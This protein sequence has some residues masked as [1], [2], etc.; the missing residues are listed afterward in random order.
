MTYREERAPKPLAAAVAEYLQSKDKESERHLLSHRQLRSIRNEMES[1][2]RHF[3]SGPIDRL[4]RDNLLAYLERGNPELKTYNNRRGLLSTFLKFAFRNDWLLENPITRT[5]HHRIGH[6]RGSPT[7]L[8]DRKAAEIMAYVEQFQGGVIAPYFALCL[9]AGIRP[10]IRNGEISK[11]NSAAVNYETKT[12]RIEPT[13]AKG[14]TQRAVRIQPNLAS[15]LNSYPLTRFPIIPANAVN[16]HRQVCRKFNLTHDILRHTFISMFV[17]KFRSIGEAAL[18]AGNSEV[19]IR[20][21]YLDLKSCEEAE[22]FFGIL[23]KCTST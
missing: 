6:R 15:W 4:N 13:V 22:A 21:H 2:L 17:A 23:P 3:P 8:D 9:F 11:L 18:Q 7:T 19:I 14:R 20:K 16:L 10:C 1:L 12:I 5:P